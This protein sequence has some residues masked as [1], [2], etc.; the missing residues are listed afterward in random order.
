[1]RKF[2]ILILFIVLLFVFRAA[3]LG[4]LG[5][6]LVEDDTSATADVAVVLATGVDYPPRLI[7]AARLYTEGRVKRVL[8]NGNRKTDVLRALERQGFRPAAPWYE[9]SLRI[10]EMCGVPRGRVWT[11]SVEDAFDTVSEAQG[12]VPFLRQQAV[13]DVI[14]TTSKFHTRRARYVWQKVLNR[15]HG[16]YTSAAASDP[17][18]PQAWWTDGRQIRQLLAEYGALVYYAWQQPWES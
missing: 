9:D 18:D 7:Q 1:M 4:A 10:L 2:L 5:E 13:K 11:V 16:I 17:F 15:E 12:I 3:W 14:I 6:S 8:I